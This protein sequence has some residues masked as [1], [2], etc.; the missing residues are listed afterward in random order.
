M[1][2]IVYLHGLFGS[3]Q[4]FSAY[5]RKEDLAI[6]LA[7]FDRETLSF[8]V[9]IEDLKEYLLNE[10]HLK[11]FHL[12]GYSLG[13]R[14][15]LQF[16]IRYPTIC[17]KCIVIGSKL[18]LEDQEIQ[19]RIIHQIVTELKLAFYPLELFFDDWYK[20]PLFQGF[21]LKTHLKNRLKINRFFHQKCL[22]QLS[23]F[24]QPDLTPLLEPYKKELFFLFG[25][26]DL[27][28]KQHYQ[29]ISLYGFQI[30]EILNASH[31]AH[32]DQ[33]QAC[34]KAM[35]KFLEYDN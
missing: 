33:Q 14:I 17:K 35:R 9:L 4:D 34:K 16:K 27:T 21:D 8:D 29:K 22:N 28:Y 19:Q 10:K 25:S 23:V 6:D 20:A 12:I 13:G 5:L 26:K 32:L 1:T 18:F 3:S 11:H 2:P 24:H 31:T 7:L 30:K 15:A